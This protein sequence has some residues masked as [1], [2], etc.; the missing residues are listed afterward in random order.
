MPDDPPPPEEEPQPREL[1]EVGRYAKFSQA[2]ER[3]LVAAALEVA[4]WVKREGRGFVLY[5]EPPQ[6]ARVAEEL[7]KFETENAQRHAQKAPPEAALPKLD[8]LPLF[9]AAWVTC[10]FWAAQNFAPESWIDLGDANNRAILTGQWWRTITALTLHG[11]LSHFMANL[12]FG[13]LFA[14]FLLPRFGGGFTWLGF[15]LAGAAGNALNAAFY[16]SENHSTIGASTAV[17]GALGMLVAREFLARWRSPAKRN[18]WHLIIPL[19]GGLALLAWLGS[20]G[21]DE[22]RID[23]MAH[24]WGFA[25]GLV[26]G[27]V[28]IPPRTQRIAAA[29]ALALPVIAWVLALKF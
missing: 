11:D 17:F 21:E 12:F 8:T 16:R 14:G 4:Y 22:P 7:A 3:G 25:A 13:L 2:Q 19:G 9:V 10:M 20:G 6:Q 5:V 24:F 29:L 27:F 1:A 15:V 23:L 18:W 28:Q 26:L